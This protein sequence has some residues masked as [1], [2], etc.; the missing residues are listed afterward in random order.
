[1]TSRLSGMSIT[2]GIPE[3]PKGYASL[4]SVGDDMMRNLP[5]LDGRSSGK[6]ARVSQDIQ[7]VLG[8]VPKISH[9]DQAEIWLGFAANASSYHT[10]CLYLIGENERDY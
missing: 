6:S 3:L 9:S 7:R 5:V 4:S 2:S 8:L 10:T 1:M